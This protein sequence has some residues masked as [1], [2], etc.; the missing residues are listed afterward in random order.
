MLSEQFIEQEPGEQ[1]HLLKPR[2]HTTV[3]TYKMY[4]QRFLRPKWDGHIATKISHP[5]IQ[6]WRQELKHDHGLANRTVNHLKGLMALVYR[7]GAWRE[8]IQNV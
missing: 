6:D 3:S 5:A 2:S 1:K 4:L 8:L 7:F